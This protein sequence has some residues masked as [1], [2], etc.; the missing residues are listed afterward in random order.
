[1]KKI[2]N[3]KG[4]VAVEYL[5][6][7]VIACL[8]A[9]VG[10]YVWNARVN[11][12]KY[13]DAAAKE[14]SVQTYKKIASPITTINSKSTTTPTTQPSATATQAVTSTKSTSSTSTS[15]TS[16]APA[17]A[18]SPGP[19]AFTLSYLDNS[20][21]PNTNIPAN[22]SSFTMP[23]YKGAGS[24]SNGSYTITAA[25]SQGNTQVTMCYYQSFTTT[26]LPSNTA[27]RLYLA[28]SQYIDVPLKGGGDAYQAS[29]NGS[30]ATGPT[31]PVNISGT[32][33]N[34][35]ICSNYRFATT[36]IY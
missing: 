33:V 22:Q 1:M 18:S 3:Q 20:G 12:N 36:P 35:Q 30:P 6:V 32:I 10:W 11:S 14:T 9:F 29:C 25:T 21:A 5:L 4:F 19:T 31:V 26:I 27:A 23:C 24:T 16:T 28:D 13:L 34:V 17:P 2:N 7:A 15:K 8:I